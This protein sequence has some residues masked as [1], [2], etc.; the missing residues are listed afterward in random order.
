MVGENT[1][2]LFENGSAEKE[3]AAPGISPVLFVC[4]GR[5]I[6]D[7]KL[8]GRQQMGRPVE[9]M[10]PDIPIFDR[11][12]SRHHGFFVTEDSGVFYTVEKTTNGILYKGELL[13]PGVT[14]KLSDGDELIIP[15]GDM[16]DGQSVILIFANSGARIHLW[17]E[18]QQASKDKLTGLYGRDSF[19]LWWYQNCK[20][21]DYRDAFLFILDVDDFKLIND[22]SGHN[23]GDMVLKSVADQLKRSVRYESQVC[24]WGGDEFVGI[25]P[26]DYS[27]AGERLKDLSRNIEKAS[28]DAGAGIT[29]S[30]GYADVHSTGNVYDIPGIVAVAD[31]ALYKVK[32]TGKNGIACT[33]RQSGPG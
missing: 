30:V 21:K 23:Q 25:F 18:F 3:K 10:V 32:Q 12:A 31:K 27:Q 13:D 8:F 11:F 6:S 7:Y 9:S 17:R 5:T 22:R 33:K 28:A 15:S 26:G 24:R 14:I 20:K 2:I 29:V 1:E 19:V 16:S 4:Q